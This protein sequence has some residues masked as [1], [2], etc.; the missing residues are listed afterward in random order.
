MKEFRLSYYYISLCIVGAAIALIVGITLD[1]DWE[2]TGLFVGWLILMMIILT[3]LIMVHLILYN[4]GNLIRSVYFKIQGYSFF[5]IVLFPFC[6]NWNNKSLKIQFTLRNSVVY[7]DF[8]PN[9]IQN[10]KLE[11]QIEIIK[12]GLYVKQYSRIALLVFAAVYCAIMNPLYLVIV[13]TLFLEMF[14][15]S[16]LKER[17]YHGERVKIQN[18]K[19]GVGILYLV[20]LEDI[21]IENMLKTEDEEKLVT[22][23]LETENRN[24]ILSGVKRILVECVVMKSKEIPV[25]VNRILNLLWEDPRKLSINPDE[26]ELDVTILFLYYALLMKDI[27][28]TNLILH[29]MQS[30]QDELGKYSTLWYDYFQRYIE[31]IE[32][33]R[34]ERTNYTVKKTPMLLVKTD[35]IGY[36]PETSYYVKLRQVEDMIKTIYC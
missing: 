27:K 23:Y 1:I 36:M 14:V 7:Y 18:I 22:L 25:F 12:K 17:K 20:G 30:I 5:P 3:M 16:N 28:A 4:F 8:L 33:S 35:S 6:I 2:D 26:K 10:K 19:R 21:Y 29:V 31:M 15:F 34:G 32:F 11:E 13:G 9:R 24:Y